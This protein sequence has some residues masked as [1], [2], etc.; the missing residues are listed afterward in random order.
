MNFSKL[1]FRYTWGVLLANDFSGKLALVYPK[2]TKKKEKVSM[3]NAHTQI[4]LDSLR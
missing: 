3:S 4:L 2:K 1:D